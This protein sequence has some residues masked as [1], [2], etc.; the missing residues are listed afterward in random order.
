[1]HFPF[2]VSILHG[3]YQIFFIKEKTNLNMHGLL[4]KVYCPRYYISIIKSK[5]NLN[6][7]QCILWYICTFQVI[8]FL[9]QVHR[10]SKLHFS[11]L[12][13]QY[14]NDGRTDPNHTCGESQ[15]NWTSCLFNF[16]SIGFTNFLRCLIFELFFFTNADVVTIKDETYKENSRNQ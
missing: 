7:K 8:F 12:Q 5:S 14:K 6:Q 10:E 11:Q 13:Y 4:I 1:M 2:F 9:E 16:T 3:I 15:V